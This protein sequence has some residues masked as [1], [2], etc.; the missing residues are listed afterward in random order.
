MRALQDIALLLTGSGQ[1]IRLEFATMS[2]DLLSFL[3]DPEPKDTSRHS[4]PQQNE[5][6]GEANPWSSR[7]DRTSSQQ[8]SNILPSSTTPQTTGSGN[9][10]VFDTTNDGDE[11][12]FGD[13][14]DACSAPAPAPAPKPAVFR[15]S[16]PQ[17]QPSPP[18]AKPPVKEV[19]SPFPPKGTKSSAPEP[20]TKKDVIGSHPFAGRMDLLF[21]A[22]GDDYDAG[23]DEL[24]DLANNPEA[25]MEYSKRMIAQQ[26]E[27]AKGKGKG[28][29]AAVQRGGFIDLEEAKSEG[30]SE[31]LKE[32][33]KDPNVLFDADDVSDD[34]GGG[35]ENDDFGD[36][37]TWNAAPATVTAAPAQPNPS[38]K[39]LSFG[40]DL[41]GLDDEP[42]VQTEAKAAP[43][44]SPQ[45]NGKVRAPVSSS[46]AVQ[47]QDDDFWD[48]F[49]T[50]SVPRQ[51][52]K[53]QNFSSKSHRQPELDDSWPDFEASPAASQSKPSPPVNAPKSPPDQLHPT[54]VPPPIIILSLFPSIFAAADEAL[55]TATS[56]LDL[57]SRTMLLA[58]PASHQ[59]L[60]GYLGQ[61]TVLARVIAGRKLRWKRDQRLTQSM[62]IGPAAAG[63]KGG[64]KLAGLD[65]SEAAK[66]DREV[67]DTLRL[68]RTQIGKLRSAV[69]AANAAPGLP[70]LP[71]IPDIAETMPV[72]ALKQSEGG[73]TARE[74]CALCGLKRE[75]RV[76]KVD[77]ERVEDSFGEWWVQ[78]MNMH[79]QCRD[80]WEGQERKLKS[81]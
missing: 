69:T 14:E 26:E 45:S 43:S 16:A 2:Q 4:I 54:N 17:S 27:S 35:Q 74:A 52:Q 67:H 63:G 34:G 3:D 31:S 76:V 73:V 77:D 22:D 7:L 10:S 11:D 1:I 59:F 57:K 62:R 75:E 15:P 65:K 61:M 49:E 53:Q 47:Q 6:S 46:A 70:K 72:K 80:F 78:G 68:Y 29:G 18:K 50:T 55:F 23:A 36:F 28:K 33:V 13:F 9:Q 79:V 42:Q 37:E 30:L 40:M 51:P 24:G 20:P 56:K 21:E 5:L 44:R 8:E 66:E 32:K 58:H 25:A 64:M 48:D 19:R 38:V 39:P 71:S 41:L 81:R 60:R 12:D